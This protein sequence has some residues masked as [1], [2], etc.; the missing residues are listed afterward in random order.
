MSDLSDESSGAQVWLVTGASR[1]LG[2]ALTRQLLAGGAQVAATARRT[3][4]LAGLQHVNP[5]RL[6]VT[7]ADMTSRQSVEA[8]VGAALE[9]FRRID[10]LVN[11]AGS[12]LFGAVEELSD[13]EIWGS[14]TRTF[15]DPGGSSA[16]CCPA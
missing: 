4:P 3:G 6:L 11:N 7:A 8:M 2:M 1:G 5:E 15:S 13:E 12:G 14:W 16:R 9:R 10:V